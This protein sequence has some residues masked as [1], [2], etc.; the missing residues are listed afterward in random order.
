MRLPLKWWPLVAIATTP[1][2]FADGW[3]NWS[4]DTAFVPFVYSTDTMGNTIGAAGMVKGAGQPSAGLLGAGLISDKGSYMTYLAA[5]NYQVGDFWLWGADYYYGRFVDSKY[6]LGEQGSNESSGL[7]TTATGDEQAFRLSFRYIV[8]WGHAAFKNAQSAIIPKRQVRGFSPATSGITTIELQPFVSSSQL[9]DGANRNDGSV[10]MTLKFDW[11][12][13][14]DVRNPSAG[15]HTGLDITHANESWGNDARWTKYEIHAGS[16]FPLGEVEEWLKQQVFAFNLYFADTPSW[17][18]C[19]NAQ[20]HRPPEHEQ[21]K[22]GGLYRLRSAES[23]RYHGRRALHY[24]A[25]YRVLPEWQPLGDWP[26]FNFYSIPWW[27]WVA[28]LDMGR[29]TDSGEDGMSE[30]HADMK[31][32][33]GGAVRFQVEGVVVR[34]EM[35]WGSE[36]SAFRVMINQPF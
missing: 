17:D 27:Q 10:G 35:A 16:Y 28:F 13:R 11:D 25:E 30:L 24:T 34:T 7:S 1:T 32:S 2:A 15:F 5:S 18:R 12:N 21:V 22:L 6:Y 14:N 9:S 4:P 3:P 29:V 8:P 26:L 33:A 31:W 23:G 36:E 19:E 20:C